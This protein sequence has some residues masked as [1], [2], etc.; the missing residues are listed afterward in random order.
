MTPIKLSAQRLER[1]FSKL[2]DDP[3]FGEGIKVIV[4]QVDHLQSLVREF[5]EFAKLPEI[6]PTKNKIQPLI[7]EIYLLYTTS[8]PKISWKQHIDP[9][10]PPFKFDS[11]AIRRV[12]INLINNAVEAMTREKNPKIEIICTY[13]KDNSCVVM[14]IKDNGPG[15]SP[16]E[17]S[18]I[19]EPYFSM[20]K[21]S[22]GLGLT[23][24]RSIVK[25]HGGDITVFSNVGKGTCFR[26]TL[27]V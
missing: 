3:A 14:E 10:I 16:K 12:V 15:L 21:G 9:Q 6:V 4:R 22:T 25:E 5:S 17:I 13:D 11:L 2:I 19:F 8:Y 20:K 18:R 7:D 1:K 24:A 27:P 23:I 26:I